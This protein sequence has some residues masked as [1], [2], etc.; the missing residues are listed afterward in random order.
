MEIISAETERLKMALTIIKK[1]V[2][3]SKRSQVF[4]QTSGSSECLG[5]VLT[6]QLL[7]V[8]QWTREQASGF[9]RQ[10]SL[11]SAKVTSSLV[12]VS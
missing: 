7:S 5:L 12:L 1:E 6:S 2:A 10:S 8:P 4:D 3:R 9:H 11:P